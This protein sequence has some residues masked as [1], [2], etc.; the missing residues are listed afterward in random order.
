MVVLDDMCPLDSLGARDS[1]CVQE[2]MARV[3]ESQQVPADFSQALPFVGLFV[4]FGVG[5]LLGLGGR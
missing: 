5:L 4:V 3:L 2:F 1:A